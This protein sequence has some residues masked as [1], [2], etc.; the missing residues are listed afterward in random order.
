VGERLVVLVSGQLFG[1][2]AQL[3]AGARRVTCGTRWGGNAGML[4][5]GSKSLTC[6]GG[7]RGN[8]RGW[9]IVDPVVMGMR[10][11]NLF[12]TKPKLRNRNSQQNHP[13]KAKSGNKLPEARP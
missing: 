11:C 13:R 5:G 2:G 3:G 1:L 6:L 4:A 8:R 7:D 9:S 10:T 12:V